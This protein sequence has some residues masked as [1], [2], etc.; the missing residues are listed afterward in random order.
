MAQK[1][2]LK[3]KITSWKSDKGYG[4]ITPSAG[5]KQ[6]FV[7]ISSFR[8]RSPRPQVNQLVTFSLST[9]QQ[10]RSTFGPDLK[11]GQVFALQLRRASSLFPNDF[12]RRGKI[13]HPEFSEYKNGW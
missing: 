1:M 6:V 8:S 9:D 10:G 3:G 12:L 2:R 7:H 4:F 13:L 5:A 11:P